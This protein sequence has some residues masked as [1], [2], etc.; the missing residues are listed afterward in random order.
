V[1]L[2]AVNGRWP[3]VTVNVGSCTAARALQGRGV[4]SIQASTPP[5]A[6]FWARRSTPA[7]V[8]L[9]L[10]VQSSG[11]LLGEFRAEGRLL[12]ALNDD[13]DQR[14]RALEAGCLD[15][16]LSPWNRMSSR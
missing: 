4:P 8:L 13:A 11:L 7:L 9:D 5:Q 16:L 1:A 12:V 14:L 2:Q 3:G 10:N 6:I 15:A